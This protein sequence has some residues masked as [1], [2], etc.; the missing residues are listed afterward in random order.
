[1]NA[2]RRL[3]KSLL[4]LAGIGLPAI[5]ATRP[6]RAILIQRSPIAGFQYHEGERLWLRLRVGQSLELVREPA[7]PYDPRAVRIDWH[8]RKLGYLPRIENTAVSQMM[9]RGERMSA[10]IVRLAESRNPWGRVEV[11]VGLEI[12]A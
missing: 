5:G 4:G 2:R 11:E 12:P 10:R 1:M 7:N 6:A 9:D 8:G 3:L